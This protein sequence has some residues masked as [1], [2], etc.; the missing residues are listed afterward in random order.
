MNV[1]VQTQ[2]ISTVAGRWRGLITIGG[3]SQWL[4]AEFTR[5]GAHIEGSIGGMEVMHFHTEGARIRF[6]LVYAHGHMLIDVRLCERDALT[7]SVYRA[8]Q[9]GTFAFARAG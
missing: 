8:G 9:A 5:R 1:Y 2:P 6:T 4:S 3:E 7:G